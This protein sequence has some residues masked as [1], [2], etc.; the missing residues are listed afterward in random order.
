MWYEHW[1][2]IY[3]NRFVQDIVSTFVS[4]GSYR[5]RFNV[6]STHSF[7]KSTTYNNIGKFIVVGSQQKQSQSQF[8]STYVK[9]NKAIGFK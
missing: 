3:T 5:K 2:G 9:K 7:A 8:V 1:L 4:Q 6:E